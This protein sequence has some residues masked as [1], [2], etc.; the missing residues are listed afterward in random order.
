MKPTRIL[1]A[2]LLT[3]GLAGCEQPAE[4]D[5]PEE[6]GPDTGATAQSAPETEPANAEAAPPG[7]HDT[8]TTTQ[9]TGKTATSENESDP[10][11]EDDEPP[12]G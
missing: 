4:Q 5:E 11:L 6:T 10:E 12:P 3:V 2:A 7:S 8:E 1:L 9:E